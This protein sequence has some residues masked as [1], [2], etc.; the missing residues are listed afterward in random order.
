MI[1]PF[2]SNSNSI[3]DDG[4]KKNQKYFSGQSDEKKIYEGIKETEFF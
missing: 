1:F 3:A 4:E 2:N